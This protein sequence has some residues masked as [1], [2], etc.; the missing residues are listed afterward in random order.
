MADT[1]YYFVERC[2][3]F[4]CFIHIIYHLY[5]Y[6][7]IYIYISNCLAYQYQYRPKLS[8]GCWYFLK[9]CILPVRAKALLFVAGIFLIAIFLFPCDTVVISDMSLSYLLRDDGLIFFCF[10]FFG[11]LGLFSFLFLNP[12]SKRGVTHFLV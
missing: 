11:A 7:Y 8:V 12:K 10:S 2:S 3:R 5:I 4:S 9:K 6:I 1:K